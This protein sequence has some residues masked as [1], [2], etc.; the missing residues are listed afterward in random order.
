MYTVQLSCRGKDYTA[1]FDTECEA[2]NYART[3]WHL[4]PIVK[5]PSGR[6]VSEPEPAC[7]DSEY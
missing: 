2:C 1:R 4:F 7:I 3:F 6:T 5:D